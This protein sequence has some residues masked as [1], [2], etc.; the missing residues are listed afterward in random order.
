MP[1][2]PKGEETRKWLE[3]ASRDLAAGRRLLADTAL[4]SQ[5]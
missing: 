4:S 5:A 2:D 1:L 3:I